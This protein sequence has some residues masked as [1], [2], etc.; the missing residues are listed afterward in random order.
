MNP[1]QIFLLD[2]S[3]FIEAAKRY[4]A[5]DI[6]PKFWVELVN[7]ANRGS[8]RSIDRVKD[9][10]DRGGDDLK[11]WANGHFHQY[12]D[13][14]IDTT[15]LDAYR[16]IMIWA[17]SQ[18]QYKDTAKVELADITNADAWLVAYAKVKGPIL[19]TEEKLNLNIQRK[20]PIPN[21][22]N[23]FNVPYMDTF[24]LLRHLGVRFQ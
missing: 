7:L 9:E 24:E 18:S 15:V 11:Q 17:Q 19:V 20:I 10:L 23:A 8:L 2:S 13:S 22:C 14:T 4:Y 1:Q 12:F 6:A 5:F 16:D 21:I 3:I